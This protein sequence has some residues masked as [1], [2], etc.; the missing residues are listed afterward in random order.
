MRCKKRIQRTSTG[1]N[2][3]YL[4]RELTAQGGGTRGLSEGEGEARSRGG[5]AGAGPGGPERVPGGWAGP[6]AAGEPRG[7]GRP[8]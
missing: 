4:L 1:D 6:G 7:A 5:S 2:K 3:R 8:G